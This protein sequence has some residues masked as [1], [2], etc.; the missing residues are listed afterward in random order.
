MKRH[1]NL[2]PK[3]ISFNN[4][5]IASKKALK[6]TT[7]KKDS[8]IY[9]YHLETNILKLQLELVNLTY[10]PGKYKYF[11]IYEPK[12]REI[13]VA[14]FIDR[15]V[16]HAIINIIEPI[17]E[18]IFINNSYAT[19]KE[20]GTHKAI[21]KAQSY[22]KKNKWYFKTDIRKYFNNINH[23]ILLNIIK[24]KIK[25]K[26]LLLLI[27]R[28]IR[29]GGKDGIG[30]PIGNLTSQFFANVYLDKFDHYIKEELQIK[31]YIRYMDDLVIFDN[32]KEKL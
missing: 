10:I 22:I 4:L 29:N 5:L 1:N 20:K 18:K 21:Y 25:D 23:N 19:R 2:Y 30:L 9:F 17:Y 14:P 7:S 26:K 28:I 27:E 11:R 13:A 8:L 16:H 12:E 6:G 31:Y 24:R 15:V 32:N 3:L